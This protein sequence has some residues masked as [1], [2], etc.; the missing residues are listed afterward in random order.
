MDRLRVAFALCLV[1][2]LVALTSNAQQTT[3]KPGGGHVRTYYV[4]ADEVE[5][6]YA[7]TGMDRMTG[8]PFEGYAKVHTERGPH[9]IGTKYLKA[10]YREYTDGTFHTLKPRA[11]DQQYLGIVGPVLHGEVGDT[12]KVVFKNNASHPYSMHP[13]GVSYDKS[14][15]GTLYGGLSWE[16]TGVVAPGKTHTYVWEVPERAG[17]G[18]TDPRS[19]QTWCRTRRESGC[20]T[21]T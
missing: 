4:A 21:A 14:S 9:R 13:H 2:P 7:P 8:K 15:E 1:L 20:T 5:W 17:P 12:I 18:P 19:P 11:P 3:V 16:E 10:C 6:D